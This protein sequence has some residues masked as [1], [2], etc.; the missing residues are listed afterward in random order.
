MGGVQVLLPRSRSRWDMAFK[1]GC[2]QVQV[3]FDGDQHYR[4]SLKIEVDREKDSVGP[5]EPNVRCPHTLPG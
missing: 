1:H 3:E 2:S 5:R 4:D